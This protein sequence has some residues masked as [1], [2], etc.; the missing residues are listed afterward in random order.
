MM[1]WIARLEPNLWQVSGDAAHV[2][3]D[4]T[5]QACHVKIFGALV[6]LQCETKI[7]RI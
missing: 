4:G 1:T 6:K 7:K 5:T 2:G 3:D